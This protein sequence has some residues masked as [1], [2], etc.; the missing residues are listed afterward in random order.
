MIIIPD[1]LLNLHEY[2]DDKIEINVNNWQNTAE[3]DIL[4]ISFRCLIF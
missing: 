2:E 1:K 4:M 3:K